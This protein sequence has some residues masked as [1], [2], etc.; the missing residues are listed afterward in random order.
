MK[1]VIKLTESDLT[2]IIER[3]INEGYDDKEVKYIND[4]FGPIKL[5]SDANERNMLMM[6]Y[7][8]EMFRDSNHINLYTD[9]KNN[10]LASETIKQSDY[11][12]LNFKCGQSGFLSEVN[13]KTVYNKNLHGYL[14]NKFCKSKI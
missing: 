10:R 4:T 11:R 1:K 2:K 5:Y 13:K 12:V 8:G 3:V 9:P 7:F 6:T 14:T